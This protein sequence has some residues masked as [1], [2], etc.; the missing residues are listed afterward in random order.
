MLFYKRI[1]LYY[2]NHLQVHTMGDNK[3][4]PLTCMQMF[5]SMQGGKSTDF[6]NFHFP[7][8][9]SKPSKNWSWKIG[10]PSKM[11]CSAAWLSCHRNRKLAKLASLSFL[12]RNA[13][14]LKRLTLNASPYLCVMFTGM[15]PNGREDPK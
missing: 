5:L 8:L 2:V 6:S 7:W 12:S 13:S 3:K 1:F 4:F 14:M 15:H 10:R 11:L 9:P